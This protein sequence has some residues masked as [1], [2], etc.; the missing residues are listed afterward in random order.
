MLT[1]CAFLS[2]QAVLRA[3][4]AKLKEAVLKRMN[5]DAEKYT[6][7]IYENKE[8]VIEPRKIE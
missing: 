7:N 1:K 4:L 5:Y 3:H 8:V 6:V 2:L